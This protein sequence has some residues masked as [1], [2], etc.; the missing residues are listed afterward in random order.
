[1]LLIKY[2]NGTQDIFTQAEIIDSN[3]ESNQKVNP[4]ID[5]CLKGKIDAHIFHGR[6]TGNFFS[7]FLFGPFGVIG[8]A[9]SN[10]KP[11]KAALLIPKNKELY[12][13]PVYLNCYKKK[14][15]GMN[16]LY[17]SLGWASWILLVILVH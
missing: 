7:G 4:I 14:A 17:S 3:K 15:R 5:N 11:K 1:M 13:D 12:K 9:L 6:E 10:P 8:A 16:I 2:E